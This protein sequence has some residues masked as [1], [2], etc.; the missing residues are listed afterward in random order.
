[1][2]TTNFVCAHRDGVSKDFVNDDVSHSFRAW[3]VARVAG[4]GGSAALA[5]GGGVR[6]RGCGG[7]M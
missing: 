3:P 2:V 4:V 7:M 5:A 6:A 1:M